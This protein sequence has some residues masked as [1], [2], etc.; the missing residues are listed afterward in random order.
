[1]TMRTLRLVGC[2]C[3]LAA[4][5]AGVTRFVA[6][7]LDQDDSSRE[8]EPVWRQIDQSAYVGANR[9]AE[10][11]T[12]HVEDWKHTLHAKMIQ[13][14][15]ADGP[16]KT[17]V[18]D[19][20]QPS[21]HR[22]FELKDVKWVIGSRWKQRF[23]GEIDDEEVVFPAQWSVKDQVWQPYGAREDWWHRYHPDWK[24][25]SN[26]KLCA[27]CHSTGVDHYTQ[28]WAELN[29]SC[30]ACHGPG[31]LHS[32]LPEIAN[33]VNPA[34]LDVERSKDVC[35][36]C[37]MAGKP[38][39]T[40]YAWPVGYQPGMVLADFWQSFGPEPGRQSAELWE[41]GTAHKNR[42]QG[43]TFEQ[44]VMAHAG[45][46]CTACHDQHGSRHQ[47]MTTKS[48]ETN[49]LCMMC[50]GPATDHGPKFV[51]ISDHTHHAPGS[52]GSRCI[53]CHMPKTGKNSVDAEARNH[54]FDFI[55]PAD[56][57]ALGVPNSC[58]TCHTDQTTDWAL[59]HTKEWYPKKQ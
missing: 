1:M 10:C 3:G 56:T 8:P 42:V 13:P 44:S 22:E 52:T 58:N 11:H 50:H 21:Q 16:D 23:I 19:F 35:F 25:R 17:I 14:A 40:E 49:A 7:P 47:S 57:L 38:P 5:S 53:E 59:L 45:I 18:A 29:I 15:V 9:C 37:H 34:R 55:S 26:F 32:D 41:N 30:E 54:T 46:Q 51:T 20:T 6:A 4:L 24:E 48:A 12:Q 43:N 31:K 27:G 28:S 2:V 33:I 36:A 39:G